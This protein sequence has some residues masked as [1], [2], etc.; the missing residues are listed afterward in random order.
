MEEECDYKCK[1]CKDSCIT[2]ASTEDLLTM[3]INCL[4]YS[5]LTDEFSEMQEAIDL[6]LNTRDDA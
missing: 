1:S 4:R 2:K 6:E 3:G 5:S